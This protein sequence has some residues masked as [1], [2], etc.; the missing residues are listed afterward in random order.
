[1]KKWKFSDINSLTNS[2][3]G[4][5]VD[6]DLFDIYFFLQKKRVLQKNLWNY[7]YF[8]YPECIY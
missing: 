2:F 4:C 5:I 6:R 1:M 7:F 3:F 8:S